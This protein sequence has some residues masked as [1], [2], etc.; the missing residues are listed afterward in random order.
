[1]NTLARS[2]TIARKLSGIAH[3]YE[4][5]QKDKGGFKAHSDGSGLT[6]GENINR[7]LTELGPTFV[8]MGQMLSLRP[9]IIPP[10]L[11]DE[12]RKL[13][14]HGSPSPIAAVRELFREDVGKYPEDVFDTFEPEPFAVASLAQVHHATLGKKKLAVKIQK[15][16]IEERIAGDLKAMRLFLSL[17]SWIPRVGRKRKPIDDAI[18]EFF[19]WLKHELDYRIEALNISRIRKNFTRVKYFRAP[20]VVYELSHKRVLVME[21]MDGVSLNEVFDNVPDLAITATVK[22]NGVSFAKK[23]FLE[24]ASS[25]VFKQVFEDGFFHADPHP[26]NIMVAKGGILTYI[27]FGI[28]GIIQP[29]LHVKLVA[30][31]RGVVDRDVDEIVTALAALDEIE[32][33]DDKPAIEARVRKLLD[34]WQGGTIVEMSVAT[35]L[36]RLAHIGYES[37]INPPLAFIVLTKTLVEYEGDLQR[38]DPSF[39]FLASFKEHIS[40]MGA[41]G[42]RKV[43]GKKPLALTVEELLH[44]LTALPEE[45]HHILHELKQDGMEMTVRFGPAKN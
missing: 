42:V 9:D 35:L 16:F 18:E 1:M 38:F 14:D 21:F 27:D 5:A 39:D 31:L 10:D 30:L 37:G 44:D 22:C 33:H 13:L 8:K 7:L 29:A 28:V 11:T 24:H 12:L 19:D 6:H 2:F 20:E 15:P 43:L 41:A 25:V 4:A 45:A 23:A 34:E 26:A 32:G 40:K 3:E 36:Y 17:A